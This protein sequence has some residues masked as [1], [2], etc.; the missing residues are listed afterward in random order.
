MIVQ[1]PSCETKF[2]IA[3]DKIS[4][5]GVKVRCSKCAQVFVVRKDS[6]AASLESI[7]AGHAPDPPAPS[8][9]GTGFAPPPA[10]SRSPTSPSAD[11]APRLSGPKDP[12]AFTGPLPDP[13][14]H[15]NPSADT[16]SSPDPD[17]GPDFDAP[18]F[19]VSEGFTPQPDPSFGT[20]SGPNPFAGP[21][22]GPA[23]GGGPPPVPDP[24]SEDLLPPRFGAPPPGSQPLAFPSDPFDGPP[25]LPAS[26][27]GSV[28]FPAPPA[29]TQPSD[30]PGSPFAGFDAH[31]PFDHDP[32]HEPMADEV[33]S[34]PSP[35]EAPPTPSAPAGPADSTFDGTEPG[36]TPI[37]IGRISPMRVGA[38]PEPTDRA[39]PRVA[40][41]PTPVPDLKWPPRVG[42]LVGLIVAVIW[43]RPGALE[44][45]DGALGVASP[46]TEVRTVGLQARP[47]ALDLDDP[48]WLITG[49]AETRGTA[50]PRGL[51]ARVQVRSG[52][53]LVADLLV[54]VGVVP[55]VEVI[56]AGPE[57][58]RSFWEDR[59]RPALGP[60][61]RTPFMAVLPQ[62]RESPDAIRIEVEYA[63]P[64]GD[65]VDGADPAP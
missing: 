19:D 61:S 9:S 58:L 64:P 3:D 63:R 35:F 38:P 51:D 5:A 46:S 34:E 26:E 53:T 13:E 42:L 52:P 57:A 30:P 41:A 14:P 50:F 33:G 24:F 22:P 56:A 54:P 23:G 32:F 28:R 48:T 16:W 39:E 18:T 31:D 43:F 60:A 15:P 1:C 25:P 2:R 10:A 44:W 11:L 55:P 17:L 27:D 40:R 12:F 4:S 59:P 8:A 7:A 49:Q 21:S 37:A 47:Y 65:E 29:L 6:S 45:A 36:G 20:P 62:L